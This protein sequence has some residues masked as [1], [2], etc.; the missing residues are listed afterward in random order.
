MDLGDCVDWKVLEWGRVDR[1]TIKDCLGAVGRRNGVYGGNDSSGLWR[2][3]AARRDTG[4]AP[5]IGTF[6]MG[7]QA[8]L[9]RCG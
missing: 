5:G 1:P 7:A 9:L 6:A 4:T 8:R 2:G 3:P